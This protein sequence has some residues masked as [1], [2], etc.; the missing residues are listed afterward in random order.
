MEIRPERP[1]DEQAL[2]SLI[3][4]AFELAEHRDGTEAAI[5]ERLRDAGVLTISLVADDGGE[6]VGQVAFSPVTIDGA[7]R[8]WFGI[9]PVAVRPDRQ[10]GGIGSRMIREGLEMLRQ[11]GAAGC[12]LVGE[13]AYY[14]RFGFRADARLVYPGI[15]PEF[16]QALSFGREVPIGTVAYHPAFG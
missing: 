15:P 16:F 4:E 11:Q 1:G 14:G 13:P 12:V 8:G 9:G 10:R 5:V 7:D 2:S 3:S 6:L